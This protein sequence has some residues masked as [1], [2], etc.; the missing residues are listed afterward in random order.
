MGKNTLIQN[1]SMAQPLVLHHWLKNSAPYLILIAAVVAAWFPILAGNPL[2]GDEYP[3]TLILKNGLDN[4]LSHWWPTWGVLRLLGQIINGFNT[5]HPGLSA[6]LTLI[7]HTLTVCLFFNV[8]QL[9]FKRTGLSLVLALIM[10]VFPWG[11]QSLVQIMGYTTMLSATLLLANVILLLEFSDRKQK[12][13]LIFLLSF[14][15][16]FIA[17]AIYENLVFSFMVS[18]LILWID[19]DRIRWRSIWPGAK[20]KIS[21]FA[22]FLGGLTFLI[23]YKLTSNSEEIT[24]TLGRSFSANPEA[25]LSVYFYQYT[26]AY[27]F[28]PWLSADTRNLMFFSW[29]LGQ[30][31]AFILLLG[32]GL[33]SLAIFLRSQRET[34]AVLPQVENGLLIYIILLLL[35]ASFLYAAAGGYSIDTRKKYALI[36]LMLLLVGWIWCQFFESRLHF[37]RRTL[38]VLMSLVLFGISTT[39]LVVGVYRYDLMRQD[40][41]ATFLVENNISGDIQLEMHPDIK[42]A[43]PTMPATLGFDLYADWALSIAVKAKRD[44]LCC[45]TLININEILQDPYAVRLSNKPSAPK[46]QFD[47]NQFRWQLINS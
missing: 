25:L 19:D 9:L 42:L 32:I 17:Q 41:L 38:A 11:Y 3:F 34:V 20:A 35:G 24:R 7:T 18:G 44:R 47:P 6:Y 22:P 10:G 27:V 36:P 43:W 8:S 1:R 45:R 39:W 23:L 40:A 33:V 30:V 26:N 12:Q 29:G 5:N 15:L 4:H 21:G 2:V 46:L 37:S 28:Q 31:V 13:P 14:V 16:T